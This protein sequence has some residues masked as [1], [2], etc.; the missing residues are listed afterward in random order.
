MN[1]RNSR[2]IKLSLKKVLDHRSQ[3]KYNSSREFRRRSRDIQQINKVYSNA[4]KKFITASINLWSHYDN[5]KS[6]WSDEL[7]LCL[8]VVNNQRKVNGLVPQISIYRKLSFFWPFNRPGNSPVP[9]VHIYYHNIPVLYPR[10]S[11]PTLPSI[12]YIPRVFVVTNELLVVLSTIY[13]PY[14]SSPDTV[15]ERAPASRSDLP[16]GIAKDIVFFDWIL[17]DKKVPA[18]PSWLFEFVTKL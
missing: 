15:H 12:V 4:T 14:S 5:T 16:Y 13:A 11:F 2:A 9:C 10:P 8:I 6:L 3:T 18:P 7:D 17:A 1:F